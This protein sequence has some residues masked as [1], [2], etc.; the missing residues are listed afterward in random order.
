MSSYSTNK[1][2]LAYATSKNRRN[3]QIGKRQS[4]LQAKKVNSKK[5]KFGRVS[6]ISGD[7][8]QDANGIEVSPVIKRVR[9]KDPNQGKDNWGNDDYS[10][11]SSVMSPNEFQIRAK[12][13]SY[14]RKRR[15]IPDFASRKKSKSPNYKGPSNPGEYN[16]GSVEPIH[17]NKTISLVEN[18]DGLRK[19]NNYGQDSYSKFTFKKAKGSLFP[20]MDN[21][22]GKN[23][24]NNQ[25]EIFFPSQMNSI[26]QQNQNQSRAKTRRKSIKQIKVTGKP[27]GSTPTRDYSN[28]RAI[29]GYKKLNSEKDNGAIKPKP[30]RV[31]GISPGYSSRTPSVSPN[32]GRG[33]FNMKRM[34]ISP[35]RNKPNYPNFGN[36]S[37]TISKNKPITFGKENT[38]S[39]RKTNK[40]ELPNRIGKK[41]SFSNSKKGTP[42]RNYQNGIKKPPTPNRKSSYKPFGNNK[43]PVSGNKYNTSPHSYNN[44]FLNPNSIGGNV[45]ERAS[46]FNRQGQ[47]NIG[48][49]SPSNRIMSKPTGMQIASPYRSSSPYKSPLKDISSKYNANKNKFSSKKSPTSRYPTSPFKR[50]NNPYSKPSKYST[51]KSPYASPATSKL[52]SKSPSVTP[53][54]IRAAPT[55][56]NAVSPISATRSPYLRRSPLGSRSP[57]SRGR[58]STSPN[59]ASTIIPRDGSA[60]RR[61][62]IPVVQRIVVPAQR[63]AVMPPPPPPPAPRPPVPVK[64]KII[65]KMRPRVPEADRVPVFRDNLQTAKKV[66]GFVPPHKSNDPPFLPPKSYKKPEKVDVILPTTTR[67]EVVTLEEKEDAAILDKDRFW[68]SSRPAGQID[69]N[70]GNFLDL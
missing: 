64:R 49:K 54:R 58:R 19:I 52:N 27:K 59:I 15:K 43:S 63:V 1:G 24:S 36:P 16:F 50:V 5:S 53:G 6:D 42:V 9:T 17:S 2:A 68:N 57:I 31:Q 22:Y 23:T 37:S 70:D 48:S 10:D 41:F 8:I 11:H 13:S 47:G 56:V 60:P 44:N 67:R 65:P 21:S 28:S 18:K 33:P 40:G 45:R 20:S 26:P 14:N 51:M 62:S 25:A 3:S 12:P 34:S 4:E 7:K 46:K 35:L 32:R 29:G 39:L 55:K 69:I 38:N 66:P 30:S 61:T